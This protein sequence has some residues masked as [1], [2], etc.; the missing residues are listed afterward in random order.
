MGRKYRTRR[1][2][3]SMGVMMGD[4][5]RAFAAIGEDVT[6]YPLAKIINP[7]NITIGSHVIIDDFAFIGN[8]RRLILGNHVHVSSH[9]SIVGGGE[10]LCC[11]FTAISPGVRILSGSDD[12]HGGGLTNSTVPARYRSV[13]RGRVIIGAHV[14]IGA[15][16]VVLPNVK[17]GEGVTVGAGSVVTKD[18]EPWGIYAGA[19][20]RRIGVRPSERILELEAKLVAEEG[21]GSRRYRS[22]EVLLADI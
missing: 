20:A 11:D 19:P 12:F 2:R 9:V 18:L 7:G 21:L 14:I 3:V 8:H 16:S 17:V 22:A 1:A 4:I 10:F 13:E 15:N 6:I 5:T